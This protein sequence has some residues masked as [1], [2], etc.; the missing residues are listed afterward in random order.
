MAGAPARD[1][2]TPD[3]RYRPRA[4][5]RPAP[6]RSGGP[7]RPGNEGAGEG[8]GRSR[9]DPPAAGVGAGGAGRSGSGWDLESRDVP[10]GWDLPASGW[11]PETYPRGGTCVLGMGSRDGTWAPGMCPRDGTCPPR[12]GTPR[13]TS[14]V[15]PVSSGWASGMDPLSP[16]CAPG[17]HPWLERWRIVG[18]GAFP[19]STAPVPPALALPVKLSAM[20]SKEG[21]SGTP[22]SMAAHSQGEG[23]EGGGKSTGAPS[24]CVRFSRRS[25]QREQPHQ[26]M[27]TPAIKHPPARGRDTSEPTVAMALPPHLLLALLLLAPALPAPHKRGLI[28]NLDTGELCLQSAQCKSGCCH[29]TGGLSLARC[30][31][32]AAEFQE[33]SPKSLYGVYY[34]CPCESGLTCDTDRT[35]VGSITNSDFG[36][37][38][39]PR[40]FYQLW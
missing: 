39:D 19:Q 31:P 2:R 30:A 37:C 24:L 15:G 11:D 32:K 6:P 5:P 4:S 23:E 20:P 8:P 9:R 33:C 13:R 38:K 34:K 3:P 40:A 22:S 27:E 25:R 35:I 10:P 12:D 18:V 7:A 26:L 36:T 21:V 1:P 14:G 17:M 16:E 28:F 29:R